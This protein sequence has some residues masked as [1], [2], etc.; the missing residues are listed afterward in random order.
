MYT[1]AP[2]ENLNQSPNR[3]HIAVWY[4]YAT[5]FSYVSSS[6][7]QS[8]ICAHYKLNETIGLLTDSTCFNASVTI[9]N[10][11]D[12]IDITYAYNYNGEFIGTDFDF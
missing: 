2:Y 6:V 3:W 8:S 12:I 11:S 9:A 1:C 10:E 7:L 4:L 5:G